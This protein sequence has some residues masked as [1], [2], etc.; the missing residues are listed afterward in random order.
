MELKD[1]IMN[2]RSIRNYAKKEVP[3]HLIGEIMEYARFAPS[4][5]NIQNWKFVVVTDAKKKKEIAEACLGQYWMTKAWAYIVVCNDYKKV[6][7]L[8]GKEGKMFSMQ[9]CAIIATYIMLLAAE[10]GIGTCWVGSFNAAEL[11]RILS[12]PEEIDPEIVLTIGWPEEKKGLPQRNDITDIIFF[13]RWGNKLAAE[14]PSI[15]EKAKGL[16]KKE[17]ALS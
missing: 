15:L 6:T 11:Q 3:M 7:T 17:P 12:L 8:Y 4:A 13:E 1:A 16:L 2:R 14:K 9:D 10:K 5:G